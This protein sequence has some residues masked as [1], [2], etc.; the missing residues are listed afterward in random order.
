MF[1]SGDDVHQILADEH[2]RAN[3]AYKASYHNNFSDDVH[4]K[5]VEHHRPHFSATLLAKQC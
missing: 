2:H 5:Q 3:E 4:V 1:I